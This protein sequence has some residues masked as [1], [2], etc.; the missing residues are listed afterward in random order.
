MKKKLPVFVFLCLSLLA[1]G[2]E[3]KTSNQWKFMSYKGLL[4]A[5]YQGWFNAE[6]DGAD[7]GWFH[8][9]NNNVFEPGHTKVDYWPDVTEYP[10]KY[11]TPFKLANGEPA[12]V[13]S[14]Y[15]ES[16]VDIHFKWMKEYG[17]D[18]V[19]MQRFV[20]TLKNPKGAKHYEKVLGSAVKFAK[21]YGRAISI[22]YDLSGMNPEDYKLV[23]ADWK[24]LVDQYHFNKKEVYEN[25][26]FHQK[27][28]LVAVWGAGFNDGRKY[29]LK[30][31]EK[32]IDF[33]KNDP[34]YGSS[35]LLGVPT[36]WRELKYDTQDD[37]FLHQLIRK[38]DIVHPWFVGRYNEDTYP[39]FQERI[40]QDIAWCN[41]NSLD[42]VP[43]AYP[44][45]S[46][47]NMRPNDP[48]NAI[49]RNKGSFF[50]KQLSGAI[51][52]GADMVYV[53]MFDEIDEGTAIFKCAQEVPVGLSR[54]VPYEKEIQP[55]HYMWL[56]GQAAGMLKKEIPYQATMPYRTY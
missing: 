21:K 1:V 23:I 19:F 36:F 27:K 11:K 17:I 9:A 28:P 30:E 42:Y 4:M 32:I 24:K 50:W 20:T 52:S 13:F 37:P 14:S 47:K 56:A 53:A 34:V 49:P 15:D 31:V 38:V 33:L 3:N 29:G 41:A 40:K 6:G 7:R 45:F 46:W 54:F 44:G 5:G 55:D 26:L 22:M 39:Q 10:I 8:Y 43:V 25:Y 18:G 16:T 51:E 48:F 35:V 12:Y 2:Q